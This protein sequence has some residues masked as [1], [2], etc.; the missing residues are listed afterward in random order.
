M[1]GSQKRAGALT[2]SPSVTPN[3]QWRSPL[4]VRF[5]S[6]RKTRRLAAPY[7]LLLPSLALI[8]L[9]VL[10]PTVQI[11]GYSF[12][13]Y[14]LPQVLGTQP[15]QWVG[16]SNYSQIISDPEFLSSL[17]ISVLFAVV[18]VPLSL[19]VGTLVGLLLHNL[20]RRMAAFVSTAALLA[21]ATPPVSASVIFVWLFDSDGGI[22]DWTLARIPSWLGGGAHW[23]GYNWTT[24]SPLPAYTVVALLVVWQGFPFIAVSVLAGLKMV[25]S[26]LGEAARVDG[27]SAWRSFWSVTF[28]ILKPIFMVLLMLSV[29]WDFG[30]FTQAYIVTGG[31][32]NPN[33]YNLGIYAYDKA[34]TTPPSY[35]L[36]SAMALVLTL[37]LLVISVW[38][39][40]A[41]IRQGATA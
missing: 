33:E 24:N 16:F 31:L 22:V 38:Y 34:F 14:G 32:G 20:G 19:A 27:A 21:W 13:N 2:A 23:A 29:I 39:V 40:R 25:P 17:K 15:S 26:E 10:W 18:V 1:L 36:A 7:L 37:V 9:L 4:P 11:G 8:A 30:V 12:Q 5:L 41:N 28:P 35:G 3:G 6:G